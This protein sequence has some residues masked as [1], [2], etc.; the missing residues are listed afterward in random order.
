MHRNI[1][2]QRLLIILGLS[3]AYVQ[4]V[5]YQWLLKQTTCWFNIYVDIKSINLVSVIE[6]PIM[7]VGF[8]D[9][10][11]HLSSSGIL[12]LFRI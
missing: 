3:H 11:Q 2:L 10:F 7:S 12:I 8:V 1:K 5:N 4:Y 6:T 9:T